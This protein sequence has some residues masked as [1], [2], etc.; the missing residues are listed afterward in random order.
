MNEGSGDYALRVASNR[1]ETGIRAEP[2]R[3]IR[4]RGL[5]KGR[6]VKGRAALDWVYS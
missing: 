4:A 6:I 1:D 3:I 2:R 5:E